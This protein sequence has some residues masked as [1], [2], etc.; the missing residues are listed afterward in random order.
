MLA[1][2][3]KELVLNQENKEDDM[4][5]FLDLEAHI[6]NG[7]FYIKTYDKQDTFNFKI[8]NYS[9]LS[10]NIPEWPAIGI[11]ISQVICYAKT[12]NQT[13]DFIHWIRLLLSKL[14]KKH[15]SK[16]WLLAASKKCCRKNP[17]I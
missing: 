1:I 6:K 14:H 15:F 5:M 13:K 16:E 10:G 17:W 8:V 2:C 9:D 4:A 12:C 7:K 3:L 11:Y